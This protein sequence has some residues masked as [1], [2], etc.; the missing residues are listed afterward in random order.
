MGLVTLERVEHVVRWLE[1]HV[2]SYD[3]DVIGLARRHGRPP[4]PLPTEPGALANILETTAVRLL[5][6]QLAR[7]PT[8]V[9]VRKGTERKYPDME[10][11]GGVLGDRLV[12]LDVKVARRAKAPARLGA[13]RRTQSRI[14]LLTGNTYFAHPDEPHASIM[15]PYNAYWVHIDWI[16]LFDI[17]AEAEMPEVSNVE[18]VIAE[19]WQVASRQRSSET[20]N[21]IGAVNALSALREKQGDFG[22]RD[23]F[24]H[25]WRREYVGWRETPG[26]MERRARYRTQAELG[27][28]AP[29]R[30]EEEGPPE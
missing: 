1:A 20:R 13:E 2:R 7:D 16:M 4:Y 10:L 19:T 8:S 5:T 28:D 22:T 17:D 9:Q 30:Q 24:E 23:E 27:L 25:F 3:F 18:H 6:E 14:T 21:Y 11:Y 29:A 12:A 26:L 15:R